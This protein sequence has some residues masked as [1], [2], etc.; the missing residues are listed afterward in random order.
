MAIQSLYQNGGYIGV[1]RDFA[2]VNLEQPLPVYVGGQTGSGIGTTASTAITFSI[3][4]GISDGT[5]ATLLPDDIVVVAFATGSTIDNNLIV[6]SNGGTAYTELADLYAN[7]TFDTNL[8]VGYR[9][10]PATVDTGIVLP[11]GSFSTADAYS[12]AIQVWRYIDTATPIDVTTTTNTSATSAISVSPAIT[13]STNGAIVIT[14]KAAAHNGGSDTYSST[15]LDF[16][17]SSGNDDTNDSTVGM[18]AIRQTTAGTFTPTAFTFSQADSTTFSSCGVT[19]ALRPLYPTG[20]RNNLGIW[21]MQS[22]YE[23]ESQSLSIVSITTYSQ[24]TDSATHWISLPTDMI[25]GN[26]LL[27]FMNADTGVTASISDDFGT[28][29]ELAFNTVYDDAYI[30]AKVI[31]DVDINRGYIRVDLTGSQNLAATIY[32]IAGTSSTV[33]SDGIVVS[34]AATHGGTIPD[35]GLVTTTWNPAENMFF[36]VAFGNDGNMTLTS[37]PTNYDLGQTFNRST[38]GSNGSTVITAAR[39]YESASDDPSNFV[40]VT[41]RS[42]VAYSLAVRPK[43]IPGVSTDTLSGGTVTTSGSYRI[44]TFTS[45]DILQVNQPVLLEYLIVGGG[46]GGGSLLTAITTHAGGGGGAGGL[47]TG[48]IHVEPGEYVVAVG[49]GGAA[50]TSGGDSSFYNIVA[51]SGG[52][53]GYPSTYSGFT[54]SQ[55]MNGGSGGG[56]SNYGYVGTNPGGTSIAGQGGLGGTGTTAAGGGGGA[57]TSGGSVT[58]TSG[59]NGGSGQASSIS[60]SSV[61]Y[62]GGGGGGATTGTGGPAGTGGGGVGAS[63]A[64]PTAGN[65]TANRG[66]GGGGARY[67]AIN[68]GGAGG[69]G[70]VIVRY[71]I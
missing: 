68:A 37:Y 40:T 63:T 1:T 14:V 13:T 6:N 70:I 11:N 5:A 44:H 2:N 66:G 20:R 55:G 26:L 71:A 15:Q 16:F 50:N 61:T 21:N 28:W 47:L 65:G 30:F 25:V 22:V 10:M 56:S 41:S 35:P 18:G 39:L 53:G 34:T 59:G 58:G 29:T 7:S 36:A 8:F 45:T 19:L 23:K 33:I 4:G 17:L 3:T 9:I 52:H 48:I 54:T 60:G 43:M 31:D 46:G 27:M 42:Y 38:V 51:F 69:S 32:Q 67:N 62:A 24:T 49:G 64:V 57:G 12:Y